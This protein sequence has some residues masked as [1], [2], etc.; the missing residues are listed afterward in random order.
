[1]VK[2]TVVAGPLLSTPLVETS[3]SPTG[4]KL[5]PTDDVNVAVASSSVPP[6]SAVPVDEMSTN[7]VVSAN[8]DAT[9]DANKA[10]SSSVSYVTAPAAF[11]FE[12][13]LCLDGALFREPPQRTIPERLN[14]I[15]VRSY[16][17]KP[18]KTLKT[19]AKRAKF[20]GKNENS[21]RQREIRLAR[22]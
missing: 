4:K 17:N 6:N 2:S 19:V 5:L 12:R 11:A 14:P 8:C 10:R 22:L 9:S 21:R 20:S 3:I 16:D 1:M 18:A 13:P 15:R 7:S